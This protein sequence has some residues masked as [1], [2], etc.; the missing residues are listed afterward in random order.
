MLLSAPHTAIVQLLAPLNHHQRGSWSLQIQVHERRGIE[1]HLL[2]IAD[3]QEEFSAG[4][5]FQAAREATR[6]ILRVKTLAVSIVVPASA[7]ATATSQT[8]RHVSQDRLRMAAEGEGPHSGRR[9]RLL[10]ALVHLR[11]AADARVHT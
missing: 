5:F 2:D 1:H 6:D 10:S 11:Q 8:E 9:H 7:L 3:V 4:H